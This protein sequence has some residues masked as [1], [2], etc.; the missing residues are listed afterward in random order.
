MDRTS[1][2]VLNRSSKNKHPYLVS[3]GIGKAFIHSLTSKVWCVL[4]LCTVGFFDLTP[5]GKFLSLLL[6]CFCFS[7]LSPPFYPGLLPSLNQESVLD[8][9]K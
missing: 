7:P 5:F 8:F 6:K 9:A 2:A 3:G 1:G 4:C